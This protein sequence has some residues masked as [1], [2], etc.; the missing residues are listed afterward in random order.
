MKRGVAVVLIGASRVGSARLV[1]ALV[2]ALAAVLAASVLALVA[3]RTAEA[4]FPGGN[5]KIA[6][7]SDRHGPVEI[8]AM[9]PGKT[10]TRI[11][12]SNNSSDPSYSPDGRRIAFISGSKTNSSYEVWVMNADG[13]GRRQVTKTSVAEQEPGWSP[14]GTRLVYASNSFD[15]DRQTDLEIWT[16]NA[17][18]TGRRQLTNNSSS[19]TQPAWSPDGSRIAFVRGQDVWVMNSDGTGESNATPTSQPGTCTS[20]CY[21]GGDESPAWSPDGSRIAYVHGYGPPANP[22]AGGGVPNIWTMDPNGGN[23]VN[24]SNNPNTSARQPAWSPDGTE[25]AYVG[26]ASGS[27]DNIYVMN[28]DGTGQRAIDTS[29]ADDSNPDWQPITLA[30]ND[31]RIREKSTNAAFTVSLPTA[32]EATITVN[33]AT[34]DGSAKTPADYT[35]ASGTLTFEPGQTTKQIAVP[36]RGDRRNERNETFFVDLSGATNAAISDAQGQAMIVDND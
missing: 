22:N 18:G 2:T 27:T 7:Q 16:I 29:I 9:T 26:T 10:A 1:A 6:F 17:D 21:Q 15:K 13:S 20:T 36:I 5:G 32:S 12:T 24:V 3:A 33:Y 28:S 35:A 31:V 14:D 8:Y 25:I 23:K 34:T 4:A 19:E 11:T 30:V